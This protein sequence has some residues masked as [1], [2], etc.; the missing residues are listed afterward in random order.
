MSAKRRFMAREAA[1]RTVAVA[2]STPGHGRLQIAP[3]PS[4]A[5]L[6]CGP[7]APLAIR[8]LACTAGLPAARRTRRAAARRRP[9]A[10]DAAARRA[11]AA[12]RA[13]RRQA[14]RSARA[15]PTASCSAAPGTSARTTPSSASGALVRPG[16]PDRL[17][18][19]PV[20]HNW[21]ASDTTENRPVGRL[22]P[23]G[24]HAAALAEEGAAHF[25]KVRFEGANYRTK[26]WL[27]GK[28]IG[29]LHRLLPVRG[30]S[31][32]PAQGPQHARGQGLLAAQQHRPH[33]LAARPPS[34]AT[35]PA[36]GGTS[37]AAARGLHAARRHGRHEHV[38]RCRG[39]GASAGRPRSRCALR[40]AT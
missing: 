11:R 14:A 27:N 38:P 24:V 15:R 10:P 19:D 40:C 13:P 7:P 8:R 37:A 34:T 23:Q 17:D 26:V 35:A 18:G 12:G 6:H 5:S 29:V 2:Q 36:A 4:D 30:R 16:R 21:N 1:R 33:P 28:Q 20:P 39:S 32:E 22:V 3:L 31:D 9:A 25:W